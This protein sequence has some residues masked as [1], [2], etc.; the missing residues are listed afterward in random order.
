MERHNMRTIPIDIFAPDKNGVFRRAANKALESGESVVVGD[1][2][3]IMPDTMAEDCAAVSIK[4]PDTVMVTFGNGRF[5]YVY[6]D[7]TKE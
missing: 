5:V 4:T 2:V 6:I 3:W 1:G 7:P